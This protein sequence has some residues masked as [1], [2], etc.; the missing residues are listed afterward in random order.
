MAYI[1]VIEDNNDII[2]YISTMFDGEII[3]IMNSPKDFQFFFHR[4]LKSYAQPVYT[5]GFICT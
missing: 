5:K 1:Y 4:A 2:G 3:E